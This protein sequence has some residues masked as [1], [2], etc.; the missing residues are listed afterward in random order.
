MSNSKKTHKHESAYHHT[1]GEAQYIDDQQTSL[2]TVLLLSQVA[3][4]TSLKL[5]TSKAEQV[6]GIHAVITSKDIPGDRFVGPIIHD[7][8][9][10]AHDE[11]L[12][13]GQA[14]AV[15]VAETYEQAREACDLIEVSFVEQKSIL[16]IQDAIDA[17]SFHN[18]P[19]R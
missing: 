16:T 7:E 6:V 8:P 10:L 1:S 13:H 9:L 5:N 11:I 17:Q 4:A 2:I 19:H 14:M 18:Q 12:Y 3:R 15:V